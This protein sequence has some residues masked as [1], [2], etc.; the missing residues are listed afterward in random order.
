MICLCMI[1]KNEAHVLA[2]CLRSVKPLLSYWVV[3]DTGSTD[4]TQKLVWDE[5]GDV[6]GELHERPWKD[7]AS[8][9]NEA[10]DLCNGKAPYVLVIDADD[11]L[12]IRGEL[13]AL[14]ADVYEVPVLY[15]NLEFL[16]PHLFRSDRGLRYKG[17]IHEYL[18][19]KAKDVLREIV[20]HVRGG[21]ARNIDPKKYEKDALVLEKALET[22][23]NNERYVFYA[24]QCWRDAG[25]LEKACHFYERR[26]QMV[27]W[28][29]ETY[30]AF[31][32]IAR[33]L[34]ARGR[35][36]PTVVD[37]YLK[38]YEYRPCRAEA[39][40]DLARYLRLK[41]R[42]ALAAVYAQSAASIQ[43]PNDRLFLNV[44]VYD[45][46]AKDEL[47]M[48]L[49][50]VGRHEEAIR[51]NQEILEKAPDEERSRLRTNLQFS[52]DAVAS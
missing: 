22:E 37:A 32:E 24:A 41:D 20:M 50:Y 48:S 34:E 7:F 5:M 27:G 26:T 39:L 13:P 30:L 12:E 3:V 17:V 42:H 31:L 47:A 35:E 46:R 38:A 21:G 19:T 25:D 4:G 44:S 10:L 8:N 16:R 29:E 45:W 49:Y 6:P 15:G 9:R 23:P 33:C 1:V 18:D 43:R 52:L 2:R 28:V 14:T 51:I 36:T 11:E 40:Y